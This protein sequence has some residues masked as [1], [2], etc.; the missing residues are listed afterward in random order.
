M[1]VVNRN[2]RSVVLFLAISI[3]APLLYVGSAGPVFVIARKMSERGW[4]VRPGF[5]M[6]LPIFKLAPEMSCPYL[7]LWGV[8]DIELFF[9]I[10]V[11][12]GAA[13]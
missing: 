4:N 5:G 11:P 10:D 9:M 6:Y 3:S 2:V 13:K 12:K 8:S 7:Q 1:I